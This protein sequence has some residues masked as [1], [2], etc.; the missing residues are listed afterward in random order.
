MNMQSLSVYTSLI[1]QFR[2]A[3]CLIG[4]IRSGLGC[5]PATTWSGRVLTHPQGRAGFLDAL[6]EHWVF[7]TYMQGSFYRPAPDD[8]VLNIDAHIGLFSIQLARKFRHVQV[9]SFE[10][11]DETF[12][13]L[14]ANL[15]SFD[16]SNVCVWPRALAHFGHLKW[17][18]SRV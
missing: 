18:T 15:K 8:V 4:C 17:P 11:S 12:Q 10:P 13:H 5:D 6:L 2:D 14:L 16:C 9:L 1:R 3:P 7:E